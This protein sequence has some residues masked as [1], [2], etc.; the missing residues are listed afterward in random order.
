MNFRVAALIAHQAALKLEPPRTRHM[1]PW[2]VG[3]PVVIQPPPYTDGQDPASPG[4]PPPQS[5]AEPLGGRPVA[6]DPLMEEPI[7]PGEA[8]PHMQGPDVDTTT[9]TGW[10]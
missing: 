7:V 9:L 2:P 3:R 6:E 5:G 8:I 1:D 10:N 4:G